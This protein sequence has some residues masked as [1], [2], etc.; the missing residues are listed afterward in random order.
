MQG[1]AIETSALG[2]CKKYVLYLK[3]RK[4]QRD[5]TELQKGQQSIDLTCLSLVTLGCGL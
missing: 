2:Y 1:D 3:E 5:I 4:K